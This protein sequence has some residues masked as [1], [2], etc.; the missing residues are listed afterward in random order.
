M[1]KDDTKRSLLSQTTKTPQAQTTREVRA[2]CDASDVA[3]AAESCP[4]RPLAARSVIT[5]DTPPVSRR[6][7]RPA[8]RGRTRSRLSGRRETR[9]PLVCF[10][11]SHQTTPHDTR[12]NSWLSLLS[13]SRLSRGF[14]ALVR[15]RT[16]A[17]HAHATHSPTRPQSARRVKISG[18][19]NESPSFPFLLP[20]HV[21]GAPRTNPT[22]Y[23]PICSFSC[24][25]ITKLCN[26]ANKTSSGRAC[27]I[28]I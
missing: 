18:R 14:V 11:K 25:R 27:V 4:R 8:T 6:E 26:S 10:P 22:I 23:K 5:D 20:M 16:H 15:S 7:T 21:F 2:P 9:E 19:S 13:L 3:A 28:S 24:Y 12:A 17:Q 1:K